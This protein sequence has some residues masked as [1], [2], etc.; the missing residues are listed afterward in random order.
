[1]VATQYLKL[2]SVQARSHYCSTR[3]NGGW[4]VC[5]TCYDCWCNLQII[6]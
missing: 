2:P 3:H 5:A 6:L 1:V 4:V